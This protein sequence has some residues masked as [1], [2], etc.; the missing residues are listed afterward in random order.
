MDKFNLARFIQAQET[1]YSYA[2]KELQEGHKRSHWIWYIFPQLKSL[3]RSSNSEFYGISCFEEASAYL[4]HPILNHR[5]REVCETILAL[6]TNDAKEVFGGI[7]S[8]KLKSSMTL[9]DIV[10]PNDIFA[11]VLEKFFSNKRCERTISLQKSTIKLSSTI[12]S[13]M[14]YRF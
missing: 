14:K 10:S 6:G 9:F 2:L 4:K 13:D 12:L 5:L 7:D 8:R 1:A 11:Q 3:G